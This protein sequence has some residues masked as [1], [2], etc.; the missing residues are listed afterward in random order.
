MCWCVWTFFRP[1]LLVLYMRVQHILF[2]SLPSL[3]APLCSVPYLLPLPPCQGGEGSAA[4]AAVLKACRREME[5]A[6]AGERLALQL[7]K[8]KADAALSERREAAAAA[9]VTRICTY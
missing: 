2:L 8:E 5:G 1:L 6:V 3:P 4:V 7:A 9:Q